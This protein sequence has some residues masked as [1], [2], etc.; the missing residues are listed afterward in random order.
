MPIHTLLNKSLLVASQ[1]KDTGDL[2]VDFL[3]ID[4]GVSLPELYQAVEVVFMGN[5]T[6]GSSEHMEAGS[7]PL[8]CLMPVSCTKAAFIM[9]ASPHELEVLAAPPTL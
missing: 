4:T 1:V 9:M 6:E 2:A 8:S 7:V 3:F 5:C